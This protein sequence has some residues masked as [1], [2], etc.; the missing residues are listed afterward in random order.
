MSIKLRLVV[1]AMAMLSIILAQAFV[2]E[3]YFSQTK[4]SVKS[5][6][7]DNLG[8]NVDF[9]QLVISGNK[10]RRY[11]KEFFI[12]LDHP[13]NRAKYLGE[14]ESAK[15]DLE[16]KMRSLQQERVEFSGNDKAMIGEWIAH[17][18][19]YDDQ[20]SLIA[21][22]KPEDR[23]D[24]KTANEK[25]K[26]GK[27]RFAIF[28]KQAET[29]AVKNINESAAVAT[30]FDLAIQSMTIQ[31]ALLSLAG[32]IAAAYFLIRLPKNIFTPIQ[33]FVDSV[34][35][36]SVGDLSTPVTSGGTTEFNSLA[37]AIDRLRITMRAT[38]DGMKRRTERENAAAEKT[39]TTFPRAVAR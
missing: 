11:E 34:N 16:K 37:D 1:W 21:N 2:A 19:F 32:A 18:A 23:M 38:I 27:D 35:K 7:A 30:S 20:F 22:A 13:E 9:L 10:L 4:K 36:M 29:E 28:L 5:I 24:T 31:F 25:I 12:F 14:W 15:S 6:V 26:P 39:I 8:R 17:L 3:H 33:G